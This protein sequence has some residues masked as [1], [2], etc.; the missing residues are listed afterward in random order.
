MS[1][2]ARRDK[3]HD[4][5]SGAAP[6][7]ARRS[8]R[9]VHRC[10]DWSDERRVGAQP[11]RKGGA[12]GSPDAQHGPSA[13]A[14]GSREHALATGRCAPRR[15]RRVGQ[16]AR[17]HR[18]GRDGRAIVGGPVHRLGAGRVAEGGR[19]GA[20][21]V[22]AADA[23]RTA[24]RAVRRG[25][26]RGD[27]RAERAARADG[28]I[29]LGGRGR[30]RVAADAQRRRR[31]RPRRSR[32]DQHRL[33]SKQHREPDCHRTPDHNG[34]VGGRADRV[35]RRLTRRPRGSPARGA[36]S[37]SSW[38]SRTMHCRGVGRR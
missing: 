35:K 24:P 11:G 31:R 38:R 37:M 36:D 21:A 20:P 13:G 1:A 25:P 27:D 18:P 4:R 8:G 34:I 3:R 2:A 22:V 15:G 19:R 30:V 16:H 14:D 5:P 26:A 10:R 9:F 6:V 28:P 17:E 12:L 32:R 33:H 7:G 23:A 29:R